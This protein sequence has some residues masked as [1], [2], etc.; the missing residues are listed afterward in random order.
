MDQ[1]IKSHRC[2]HL[3]KEGFVLLNHSIAF[4]RN[5]PRQ[6]I[7]AMSKNLNYKINWGAIIARAVLLP[8]IFLTP[9]LQQ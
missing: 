3:N 5:K 8:V 1:M 9:R 6:H 7:N 4:Q 2:F